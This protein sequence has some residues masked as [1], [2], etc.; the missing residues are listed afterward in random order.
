MIDKKM[1]VEALET[2]EE[3]L[4]TDPTSP[5]LFN[6]RGMCYYELGRHK[7]ALDSFASS[8]QLYDRDFYPHEMTGKCHFYL[9]DYIESIDSFDAASQ[10]VSNPNKKVDLLLSAGFAALIANDVRASQY[11]PKAIELNSRLTIDAIQ[12]IF[13][14]LFLDPLMGLTTEEKIRFQEMI[15]EL[16]DDIGKAKEKI[17]KWGVVNSASAQP[18]ATPPR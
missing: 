11:F 10:R 14:K 18:P 6:L 16:R 8:L 4:R 9:E 13:E 17:A 3:R 1:I 12:Q 2:I 5:D 15:N 7:E